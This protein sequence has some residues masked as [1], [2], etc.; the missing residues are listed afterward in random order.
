[1]INTAKAG[2][3]TFGNSVPLFLHLYIRG[4]SMNNQADIALD[5]LSREIAKTPQ[6]GILYRHRAFVYDNIHDDE[7]SVADY[8]KAAE[9]T[10]DYETLI[11]A[12]RKIGMV[13]IKKIREANN[14]SEPIENKRQIIDC[15][16]NKA[17]E[18]ATKAK[19]INPNNPD[20][21]IIIENITYNIESNNF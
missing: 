18:F 9:L 1:M 13:G 6:D 5:L 7:N 17:L 20:L 4:L 8:I 16:F 14:N 19:A 21:D 3:E 12:S 2:Y 10:P 15:Y 11:E